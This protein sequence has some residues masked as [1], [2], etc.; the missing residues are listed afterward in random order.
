MPSRS[1][2]QARLMAAAAHSRSFAKKVGVP[3]SVAMEFNQADK[4]GG[5]LRQAMELRDGK[6][7]PQ[8]P[9]AAQ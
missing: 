2:A 1:V 3:P 7:K 9:N 6:K 5:L 8:R 4:S